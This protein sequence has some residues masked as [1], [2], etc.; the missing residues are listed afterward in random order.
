MPPFF[1]PIVLLTSILV[2][3]GAG[4]IAAA[5]GGWKKLEKF[6]RATTPFEGEKRV[7]SGAMGIANYGFSLLLGTDARGFSLETTGFV[8]TGHAP[9][10][11]PWTDV[12]AREVPGLVGPRVLVE[13]AKAPGVVLRLTKKAVLQLKGISGASQA[14]PGI[15]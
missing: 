11:I 9:L 7:M 4:P 15:A 1:I 3:I 6:Y 14:F 10:F 13:F 12:R 8:R 5:T 2:I